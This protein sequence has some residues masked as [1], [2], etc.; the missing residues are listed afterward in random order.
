MQGTGYTTNLNVAKMMVVIVGC[1][2]DG[3][4]CML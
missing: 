3:C 2:N 1:E 4:D